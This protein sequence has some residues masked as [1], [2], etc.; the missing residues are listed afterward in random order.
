MKK[1]FVIDFVCYLENGIANFFFNL[2]KLIGWK[3]SYDFD[4]KII[5]NSLFK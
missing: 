1:V 4:D 3:S 5:V 2:T